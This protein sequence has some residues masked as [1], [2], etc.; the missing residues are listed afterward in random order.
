MERSIP[1]LQSRGGEEDV[2]GLN[3]VRCVD[4]VVVGHVS[5]VVVLQGH[6]QRD[7]SICGNLKGLEQVSLLEMVERTEG[8]RVNC[9]LYLEW[10]D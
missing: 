1:Y 5:V 9:C 8:G 3:H 2:G 7:E 4:V 6:H 10:N